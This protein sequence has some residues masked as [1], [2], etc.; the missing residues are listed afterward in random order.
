MSKQLK[1]TQ[2][3][4][5]AMTVSILVCAI[6]AVSVRPPGRGNWLL[7][8]AGDWTLDLGNDYV[9]GPSTTLPRGNYEVLRWGAKGHGNVL[10]SVVDGISSYVVCGDRILL[11]STSKDWTVISTITGEEAQYADANLPD[12]FERFKTN[13]EVPRPSMRGKLMLLSFLLGGVL[14]YFMQNRERIN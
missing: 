9:I 13:L 5:V 3:V 14:F 4:I 6:A 11:R 10:T 7:S 2:C 12:Q 8:L 1:K